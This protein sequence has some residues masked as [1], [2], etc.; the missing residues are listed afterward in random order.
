ML[1][2]FVVFAVLGFSGCLGSNN[3][4]NLNER[5]FEGYI[6][7][8]DIMLV[9]FFA[10]W[11]SHCKEL[12]PELDAAAD[13][14]ATK[15]QFVF[16]KVDCV[17]DGQQLCQ[18]FNIQGYP[19]IKLFKYG[20]YVGD[21]VGQRDRNS[22]MK[23][24]DSVASTFTQHA[25]LTSGEPKPLAQAPNYPPQA[26]LFPSHHASAI[27]A[28]AP[29]VAP[30]FL[31]HANMHAKNPSLMH[32]FYGSSAH[33]QH[34]TNTAA[35]LGSS[36]LLQQASPD[37]LQSKFG[38]LA[39][40]DVYRAKLK[41]IAA[42]KNY[43]R[44]LK[45]YRLKLTSVGKAKV[46]PNPQRFA[47]AVTQPPRPGV[48]AFAQ[49]QSYRGYY[50]PEALAAQNVQINRAYPQAG[51]YTMGYPSQY[52][53]PYGYQAPAS[54]PYYRS[55]TFH[56][57]KQHH[58][59]QRRPA[60][61]PAAVRKPAYNAQ[62]GATQV[63]NRA[64]YYYKQ[65]QQQQRF[66]QQPQQRQQQFR[67]QPQ[68]QQFQQDSQ[69]Q[70]RQTPQQQQRQQF[71]QEP[72]QQFKQ[73]PQ[74]QFQQEPHKEQTNHQ[75]QKDNNRPQAS[76]TMEKLALPIPGQSSDSPAK[77]DTSALK[78][79]KADIESAIQDALRNA[80]SKD[81]GK[82]K[83]SPTVHVDGERAKPQATA[84]AAEQTASGSGAQSQSDTAHGS[85][86]IGDAVTG[87]AAGSGSGAKPDSP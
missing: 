77:P 13:Q 26:Q 5:D 15:N 9:D 76:Q 28:P 74:Q 63:N 71:Q 81:S 54:S 42:Y 49:P 55:K 47:G 11:C 25:P 69:Q 31:N 56:G 38:N 41:M 64:A 14:L 84:A 2:C 65:K 85:G 61:R 10:P 32:S 16:A 23:Y 30:T 67:Q 24:V 4:Y 48:N 46:N 8:K 22:L 40:L 35:F 3:V 86:I 6:R 34:P 43:Q 68:R 50:R 39:S 52:A 36:G 27:H 66:R 21:Y 20:Q 72:Q 29:A 57:G 51:G 79:L 12:S 83:P 44:R 59:K 70:F 33:A 7:D 60:P 75:Q 1:C 80:V 19:T 37:S 58:G 17:N 18:R 53:S 87:E 82:T 78:D 62:P 73:P 45:E